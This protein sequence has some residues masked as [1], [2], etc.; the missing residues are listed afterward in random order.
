MHFRLAPA[1]FIAAL[2][3]TSPLATAETPLTETEVRAMFRAFL[4]EN[5]DVTYQGIVRHQQQQQLQRAM[6][7]VRTDTPLMGNLD[8]NVTLIEFSDF[9]CPYCQR[10]QGTLDDIKKRYKSRVRFAYKHIPLGFHA[11]A[12]AAS[13]AAMAAQEQG[14]FWEYAAALYAN[15][16]L[17]GEKLYVSLAEDLGLN[18]KAFNAYRNSPEAE[19]RLKQDMLDADRVGAKGTPYFLINGQVL[20]GAQPKTAFINAIEKALKTDNQTKQ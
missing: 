14:K 4:L 15:Q 5:G 2:T 8:A 17:L 18:M 7:V 13:K 6:A 12:P 11:K 10:V 19:N 20:S 1:A 16:S 3:L 9:E